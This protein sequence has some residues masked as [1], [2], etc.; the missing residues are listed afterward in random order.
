[1]FEKKE[2]E[3]IDREY[4]QVI[5]ETCYHLILKSKNTGHTWDITCKDNPGGRSLVI[6]HKHKD[7]YPFHEQPTMLP[8]SIEDARDMIKEHDAWQI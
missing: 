8:R 2:F 4:F 1:M 6:L 7:D 5:N 3:Y